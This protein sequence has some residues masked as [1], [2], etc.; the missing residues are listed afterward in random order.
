VAKDARMEQKVIFIG[1]FM[2]SFLFTEALAADAPA[3]QSGLMSFLPMLA[4]IGILYFFLIRPQQK[5]QKQHQ[6]LLSS[7]KKGDKVITSGG[8]VATISK[9]PNEHEVILEVAEGVHCK[10][11]KSSIAGTIDAL[12]KSS[13]PVQETTEKRD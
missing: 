11:A 12:A 4:F 9:I 10:F 6:D 1:N 2:V 7:L 5:R 8:L 13:T 3:A